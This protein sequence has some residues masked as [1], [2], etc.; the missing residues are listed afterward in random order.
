[1]ADGPGSASIAAVTRPIA[2]TPR[3]RGADAERLRSE[4]ARTVSPADAAR[5][6]E[7]AKR[8]LAEMFRPKGRVPA[9]LR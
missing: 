7:A 3:L 5:R 8:E 1:V 4:L 2:P 6:V 9:W